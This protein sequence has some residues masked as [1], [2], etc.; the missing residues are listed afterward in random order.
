[1]QRHPDKIEFLLIGSKVQREK[2]FEMFSNTIVGT[3]SN[4]FSIS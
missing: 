4:S 2:K 1:M 3:G